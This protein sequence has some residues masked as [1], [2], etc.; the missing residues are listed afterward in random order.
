MKISQ[1]TVALQ[2]QHLSAQ[3]RS[4]E[5]TMRA[6]VGERR[7]DFEGRQN[8][9]RLISGVNLSLSGAARA[10]LAAR[11]LQQDAAAPVDGVR[12]ASDA[13][14]NDPRLS[15]LVEMVQAMTGRVVQVFD[16]RELQPDHV[17][18]PALAAASSERAP[19][20]GAGWGMELQHHEMIEERQTTTVNAQGIVQTADGQRIDFSLQL[21][22]SRSYV[23]ESRFSLR[24][25][26]AV[27]KDPLVI[28]FSGDGAQLADL[29][30]A[31]DLD[32]DGQ[33]E[34]MPFVTGG[35][36]FLV[37]DRNQDG[38]VNDGSELFGARSGDGFAELAQYDLDGN[39]W[40]DENDAVYRQL[41]VWQKNAQ[42]Q[43]SLR[44]LAQAGVG[45]LHLGQVASPFSLNTATNQTLGLVRGTGV[46]LYETGQVGT[47]QQ[48]DLATQPTQA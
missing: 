38:K 7:P 44:T 37:L 18:A 20:R 33:P 11:R 28:N 42:G 41:Q 23:E 3:L 35:S 6:W 9:Q 36:G 25:G 39:Q 31:F 13:V 14:L 2:S 17:S 43:D 26:D 48:V 15:L 40:I 16:A 32:V 12:Q 47:M 8:A 10:H 29:Q 45:A 4:S 19:A 22:M 24:A 46:F 30:F 5:T 27:L 21:A 1:S 34:R